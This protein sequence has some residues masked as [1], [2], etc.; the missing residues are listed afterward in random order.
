MDT[1]NNAGTHIYILLQWFFGVNMSKYKLLIIGGIL[2]S[3]AGCA[4]V[5]HPHWDKCG[6]STCTVQAINV[7]K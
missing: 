3:L 7:A 5:V 1:S 4:Y 2:S 6:N